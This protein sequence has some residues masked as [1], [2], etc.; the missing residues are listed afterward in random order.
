[1]PTTAPAPVSA[2]TPTPT[3]A[4]TSK[5]SIPYRDEGGGLAADAGGAV[6]AA[7]VLLALLVV[8][9]QIARKRGLLDR[10][11][12]AAPAR[13]EGR[14]PMRVEEALRVGPRTTLYRIRDGGRRYLLIESTA[15][16]RLVPIEEDTAFPIPDEQPNDDQR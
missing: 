8:A 1:M 16:A 11:I 15:Q 10:W 14:E 4:E 13:A 12:P 7:F 5:P 6:F 3:R 9:L 2:P